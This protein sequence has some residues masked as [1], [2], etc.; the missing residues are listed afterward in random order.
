MGT[1]L[2]LRLRPNVPMSCIQ[3]LPLVCSLGISDAMPG[4]S[5]MWPHGVFSAGRRVVGVG[6]RGG[7]DEGMYVDLAVSLAD[8]VDENA[9]R[10]AVVAR[11]DQWAE[12]ISQGRGAAG[13]LAP[14]LDE[15]FDRT[16]NVG[17]EVDVFYPNGRRVLHGVFCGLDVWG[18][19]TVR[20][21]LGRPREFA[22]E[23]ALIR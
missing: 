4:S 14:V 7:Y 20:D 17:N 23:Q 18:R 1:T 5:V 11:V 10:D 8:D 21:P 15:L 9:I 13:P 16:L 2:K 12:A 3:A 6:T 22:P 19:A